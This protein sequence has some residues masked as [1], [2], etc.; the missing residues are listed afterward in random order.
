MPGFVVERLKPRAG[1]SRIVALVPTSVTNFVHAALKTA[2]LPHFRFHDLRHYQASILHA[3]GVPD[4][5]IMERGGWKTDSTLKNIYQHTMSDKRREI[6]A[7]IIARF[8]ESHKKHDTE[9]DT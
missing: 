1:E 4:K 3:M 9:H 6:E 5:Y 7:D 2:G 8:E